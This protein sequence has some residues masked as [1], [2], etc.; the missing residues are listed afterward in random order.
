MSTKSDYAARLFNCRIEELLMICRFGLLIA[1]R[2]LTDFSTFSPVFNEAYFNGFE[3]KIIAADEL[4]SPKTETEEMKK[5]TKALYADTDGLIEPINMMRGYLQLA[6]DQIGVSD[7]DFGLSMLSKKVHSRDIEGVRQN[8]VLVNK[9][10]QIYKPSLLAVGLSEETV[11]YLSNAVNSITE[12]NQR[13]FEIIS[14]RKQTV[15]ENIGKL[16]ELY[17]DLMKF[18]GIGRVIYK[19]KDHV[20]AKEYTFENLK[21]SVRTIMPPRPAPE[22][23]QQEEEEIDEQ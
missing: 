8:L 18:L 15:S 9:N 17:S 22:V 3:T 5:I 7:K 6:R 14:Q 10:V 20:K 23:K 13:Q 11:A 12:N 2:D 19:N 16:N 4:V 21:K 1:R